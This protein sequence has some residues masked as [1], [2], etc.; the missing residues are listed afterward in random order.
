MK[1]TQQFL[2]KEGRENEVMFVIKKSNILYELWVGSSPSDGLKL[3]LID[4]EETYPLQ[5]SP[6]Q[7]SSSSFQKTFKERIIKWAKE[8]GL[9]ENSPSMISIPVYPSGE[10]DLAYLNV[11]NEDVESISEIDSV[12]GVFHLTSPNIRFWLY[13]TEKDARGRTM[14][15]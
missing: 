3:T 7:W 9:K 15:G 11:W 6:V 12:F 2:I 1:L 13:H 4:S 14:R 5:P 8:N 10:G